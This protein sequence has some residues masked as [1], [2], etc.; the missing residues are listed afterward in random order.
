[1]PAGAR[2]NYKLQCY[3]SVILA[4]NLG[5]LMNYCISFH[6]LKINDQKDDL[7]SDL[8]VKICGYHFYTYIWL[9]ILFST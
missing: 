5:F 4:C 7:D 9:I 1:M 2:G 3:F 6:D 8:C